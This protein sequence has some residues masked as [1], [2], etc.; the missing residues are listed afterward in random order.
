M[1]V[2]SVVPPLPPPHPFIAMLPASIKLIMCNHPPNVQCDLEFR[3]SFA[4]EV[5]AQ[6]KQRYTW[7]TMSQILTLGFFHLRS[8]GLPLWLVPTNTKASK[9]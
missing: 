8:R 7:E 4:S 2:A 3:A 9:R 6:L 5:A 1:L